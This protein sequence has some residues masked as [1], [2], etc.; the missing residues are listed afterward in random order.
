M[1]FRV[2]QM[3]YPPAD[4]MPGTLYLCTDRWNDFGFTTT[5]DAVY[6]AQNGTKQAVGPVKIGGIGWPESQRSPDL[7]DRF[8]ALGP[9]FVSVGQDDEYYSNLRALPGTAG[10]EIL[11][12]LR[13]M[14]FDNAL[15]DGAR[16][17]DVVQTSLLR[18]VSSAAVVGRF[19]RLALGLPPLTPYKFSYDMP[20]EEAAQVTS[21]DFEVTVQANPPTNVHVIVG[22][23]GSGKTR[24]LKGMAAAITRQANDTEDVGVFRVGDERNAVTATDIA[25]VVSVSFSAFDPFVPVPVEVSARA[26]I[27]YTYVGLLVPGEP[28]TKSHEDLGAEFVESFRACMQDSRRDRWIRAIHTLEGDPNFAAAGLRV[29]PDKWGS[30]GDAPQSVRDE[31]VRLF[32]RLSSGHGIVLLMTTRLVERVE[33]RTLVL[34]DEPEAH[35]HPPL[36]SAFVRALSDLLMDRNGVAV[37]ATHS[38]VVLQ[39]VPSNCVLKLERSGYESTVDRPT[40]ETFGENVGTLTREVFGLEVLET[41]FFRML[42]ESIE[43]NEDFGGVLDDFERQLGSEASALARAYLAVRSRGIQ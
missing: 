10:E 43:R 27:K 5:F 30:R 25:N 42:R 20:V 13:D 15:F 16:R 35:L 33:E 2:V 37:L 29:L 18:S 1:K 17:E 26:E 40:I 14:A 24:V 12:G 41:G 9:T 11:V 6:V 22:R 23:N 32:R 28:R 21:L 31:M 8:D 36:L 38:P 3:R 34:L 4:A 19:R 39:E 7:P